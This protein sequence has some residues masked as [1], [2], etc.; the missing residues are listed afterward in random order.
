MLE[1]GPVAVVDGPNEA[2]EPVVRYTAVENVGVRDTFVQMTLLTELAVVFAVGLVTGLATGLGVAPFFVVREIG[3]RWLVVLWGLAVGI[4]LS[5]SLFG[6]VDEALAVGPTAHVVFGLLAGATFVFV[7]DRVVSGHEFTPHAVSS[8]DRVDSR[9]VV[10]TVGVLTIH[11]IPEGIAV[12]VAF[13]DPDPGATVEIAGATVPALAVFMGAAISIL[14]VPEG[15]AIAIPLI[16]Y[17]MDRWKVLGWALFSGLPQPI[18]AVGAYYFV[19]ALEG[20]LAVSFGFAAGALFYLVVVEFVPAGL[21]SGRSLPNRGRLEL[22]SGV[23]VGFVATLALVAVVEG[24]G[25]V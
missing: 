20:L 16:A 10:L 25:T 19:S 6:L 13:V 18:G 15:L 5:A 21:E 11:S 17:G 9:L 2:T 8:V 7:A 1:R 3:D 14:N 22:A 12:G 24:I 23:V 4:L